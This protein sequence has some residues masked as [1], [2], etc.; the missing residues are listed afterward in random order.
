MITIEVAQIKPAQPAEKLKE[1]YITATLKQSI[2]DVGI[3]D[4]PKIKMKKQ[5]KTLQISRIISCAPSG[6]LRLL[7]NVRIT[8]LLHPD[9]V[10]LAVALI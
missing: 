2:S 1:K 8:Y 4:I 10:N 6:S 5:S 3:A 7:A 9:I